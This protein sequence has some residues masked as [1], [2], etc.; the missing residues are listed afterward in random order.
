VKATEGE[1]SR[2]DRVAEKDESE[3]SKRNAEPFKRK[4]SPYMK[5]QGRTILAYYQE[6]RRSNPDG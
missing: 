3:A 2:R 6:R 4:G 1:P 5:S